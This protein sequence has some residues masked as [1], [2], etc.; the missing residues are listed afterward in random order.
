MLGE[1]IVDA[2]EG[3]L[4]PGLKELWEWREGQGT[5]HGERE[6]KGEEGWETEDGTRGGR[7]GMIYEVE[8]KKGSCQ[9]LF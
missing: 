4:E 9:G 5:C 3:R 7:R 2:I 6:R 1:K 8:M